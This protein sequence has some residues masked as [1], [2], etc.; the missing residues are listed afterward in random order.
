MSTPAGFRAR[1]SWKTGIQELYICPGSAGAC[2]IAFEPAL[3][4]PD[5][6]EIKRMYVV[7]ASRGTGVST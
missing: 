6:A 7:P 1:S 5:E 4:F 3:P 2:E